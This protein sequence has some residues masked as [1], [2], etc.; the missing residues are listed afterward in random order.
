MA[1]L[2]INCREPCKQPL[3]KVTACPKYKPSLERG[4]TLRNVPSNTR[5][6]VPALHDGE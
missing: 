6:N 3:G 1:N 4:G 5:R 2:C